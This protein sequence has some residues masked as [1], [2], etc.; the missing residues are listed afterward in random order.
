[1]E[2]LEQSVKKKSYWVMRF[3]KTN[4]Y[5][6]THTFGLPGIMFCLAAGCLL[7]GFRS[8]GLRSTGLRC[9]CC[10]WRWS[11]SCS[12]CSLSSFCLCM[13]DRRRLSSSSRSFKIAAC[14]S[15]FDF[16]R[17]S[18][19]WRLRA[20]S[21]CTRAALCF[22]S[23]SCSLEMLVATANRSSNYLKETRSVSMLRY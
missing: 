7:A 4:C 19:S 9:C 8:V 18:S 15:F 13:A 14:A 2:Y 23:F 21:F 22:K 5:Y 10:F 11:N 3:K 17:R 16:C 20:S 6:T 1:M 12:R